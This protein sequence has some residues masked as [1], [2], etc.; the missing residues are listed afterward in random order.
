[1][2]VKNVPRNLLAQSKSERILNDKS[3]RR[4]DQAC[5]MVRDL[6]TDQEIEI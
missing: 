2:F 4:K 3:L 1:M 5:Y 6:E